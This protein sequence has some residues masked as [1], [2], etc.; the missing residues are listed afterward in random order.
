MVEK[1]SEFF[2][3]LWK[4]YILQYFFFRTRQEEMRT[5]TLRNYSANVSDIV[6]L[7]A[8]NLKSND[9]VP[10]TIQTSLKPSKQSANVFSTEFCIYIHAAFVAS[11]LIIGNLRFDI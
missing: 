11:I 6:K 7:D 1:K 3:N 9:T 2:I 4:E 5:F 10:K 8:H